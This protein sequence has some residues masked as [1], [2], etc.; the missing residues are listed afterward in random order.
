MTSNSKWTAVHRTYSR[1]D[2]CNIL[3][4]F[5]HSH[6]SVQN[7]GLGSNFNHT[8][9]SS[10]EDEDEAGRFYSSSNKRTCTRKAAQPDQEDD[11]EVFALLI[12]TP[13]ATLTFCTHRTTVAHPLILL[14][15]LATNR[16][17]TVDAVV[18]AAVVAEMAEDVVVEDQPA[19]LQQERSEDLVDT[20]AR[21]SRYVNSVGLL[22][23]SL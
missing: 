21:I 14:Q 17:A 15:L 10:G 6:H 19:R 9:E 7:K 18:G 12:N 22:L 4:T 23:G 11:D 20:P 8:E 16:Q 2:N 5:L 1:W 3:S 13:T